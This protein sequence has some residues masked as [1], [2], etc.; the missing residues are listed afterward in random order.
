MHILHVETGT[1]L[2]G[3]A[4]QV[5]MLLDGLARC[6]VQATLGCPAGSAVG[7]AAAAAGHAV[8]PLAFRSDLD[9][10]LLGQLTR[11]IDATGATLLHAHSRR[12]ADFYGGL[13]ARGRVPAVLTR[14]V[15]D[16]D[17]PLLGRLKYRHYDRVAA[18]SGAV[19]KTLRAAGV[20]EERLRLVRSAVEE[21]PAEP[22]WS[23]ARYREA[24]GLAPGERSIGVVAQ[25]IP[26]KGHDLLLQAWPRLRER[27]GPARLLIFGQGPLEP[28][29][30]ARAAGDGSI[31]FAGFRPDLRQFL[32]HLDLVL[33]GAVREGL[34]VALLEAQAAGVP[35][36]GFA[37]G[38]VPEAVLDG[39]TGSLVS[40]GDSAALVEAAAALLDDERLRTQLGTAG[41]ERMR[42][43]FSV[44]RMTAA[45]VGIYRELLGETIRE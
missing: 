13:A 28:V 24:F 14:R 5:L 19:R 21:A 37:A 1:R 38:G 30:R 27:V 12:G 17:T 25:L 33:H 34:G 39:V 22:A 8:A 4:R 43:E 15:D 32:G 9:P 44:A 3:G 26:R 36:V 45:Y 6:G 41:R 18:I 42:R 16:P 31:V 20:P 29:L 11:L 2:Y 7:E 35:V 23:P 40:T 10:R